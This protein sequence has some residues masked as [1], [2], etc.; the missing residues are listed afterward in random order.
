MQE[1][2]KLSMIFAAFRCLNVAA[3]CALAVWNSYAFY[4]N[5]AMQQAPSLQPVEMQL[6]PVSVADVSAKN[7]S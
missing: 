5:Q 6:V 4:L 1:K 2:N 7:P 3:I